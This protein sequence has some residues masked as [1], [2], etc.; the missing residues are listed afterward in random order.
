M[1]DAIVRIP[2]LKGADDFFSWREKMEGILMSR[3]RKVWLVVNGSLLRPN[4]DTKDEYDEAVETWEDTNFK[5]K[6]M[7]MQVMGPGPMN[8]I[9][10][11]ETAHEVWT[12]LKSE[13]E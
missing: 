6:G 8:V 3:G 7:L 4:D 12:A 11:K 13:Y 10:G 9:R 1:S 5:A 2:L